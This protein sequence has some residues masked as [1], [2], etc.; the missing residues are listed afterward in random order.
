ML[1]GGDGLGGYMIRAVRFDQSDKVFAGLLATLLTELFFIQSFA[2][3]RA[4]LLVWHAES[5]A[6]AANA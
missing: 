5:A 1:T 4:K 6:V 3:L 2:F